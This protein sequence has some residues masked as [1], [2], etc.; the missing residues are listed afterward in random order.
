MSNQGV[1]IFRWKVDREKLTGWPVKKITSVYLEVDGEVFFR[2]T[3]YSWFFL[4]S[5]GVKRVR[6]SVSKKF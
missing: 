3:F 6:N 4:P 2:S 1:F 5:F